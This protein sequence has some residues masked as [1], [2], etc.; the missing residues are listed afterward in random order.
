MS[1]AVVDSFSSFAVVCLPVAPLASYL[2]VS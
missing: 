2:A 1:P